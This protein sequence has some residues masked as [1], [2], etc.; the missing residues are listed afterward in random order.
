[1]LRGGG[2]RDGRAWPSGSRPARRP[3]HSD[4]S[5]GEDRQPPPAFHDSFGDAIQKALDSYD[6]TAGDGQRRLI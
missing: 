6:N 1:M 3:A 4:E 2:G 5:D